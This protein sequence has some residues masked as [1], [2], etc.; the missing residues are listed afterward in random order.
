MAGIRS[1]HRG[2]TVKGYASAASVPLRVDSATNTLK[3]IP[4]G[5]GSAEVQIPSGADAPVVLTASASLTV[6]AH[7]GV[8]VVYNNAAGGTLTLPNATG[9][10]AKFLIFIGTTLTGGSFVVQVSRAAD[11]MRG[12]ASTIG[13]SGITIAATANNPASSPTN[14]S[15]TITFN[16]STTGLGTIGDYIELLDFTPNVWSVDAIYASSGAAATPFSAAV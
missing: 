8:P 12:Q 6:A 14:E 13:S 16:R 2:P 5:S 1:I 15:D 10:G 3:F 7:A 4:A 11:Y 9:S